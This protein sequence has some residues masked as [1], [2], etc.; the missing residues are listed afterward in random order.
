MPPRSESDAP[1]PTPGRMFS[2][3]RMQGFDCSS[4]LRNST[5]QPLERLRRSNVSTVMS[6]KDSACY[7]CL[8]AKGFAGYRMDYRP[9]A[10]PGARDEVCQ[11]IP[12]LG[13]DDSTT[14]MVCSVHKPLLPRLMVPRTISGAAS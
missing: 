9:S 1:Q 4:L 2:L 7:H 12:H 13:A 10:T 11:G 14:D 3:F 5:N 8:A 6:G